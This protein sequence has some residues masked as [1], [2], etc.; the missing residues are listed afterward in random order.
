M[1]D[2]LVPSGRGFR[3]FGVRIAVV[4]LVAAL[5]AA[6]AEQDPPTA[7]RPCP[8]AASE[9]SPTAVAHP[10]T[11]KKCLDKAGVIGTMMYDLGADDAVVYNLQNAEDHGCNIESAAFDRAM[12]EGFEQAEAAE[13]GL[14]ALILCD[15]VEHEA[16]EASQ[17]GDM[18]TARKAERYLERHC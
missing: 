8:A 18:A 1:G 2:S 5:L 17:L 10:W 7:S 16:Y 9:A 15:E 13:E 3:G 12:R 6:C 4:V 14:D 11:L